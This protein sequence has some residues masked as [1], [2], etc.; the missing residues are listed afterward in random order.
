MRLSRSLLLL[1][2]LSVTPALWALG[3]ADIANKTIRLDMS[4][5]QVSRSDFQQKPQLPWYQL[6]DI[7]DFVID[8]PD[9]SEFTDTV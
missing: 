1:C 3:P 4:R 5:A 9:T 7:T 8:V 6:D 2:C